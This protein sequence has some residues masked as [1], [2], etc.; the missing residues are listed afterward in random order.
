[1]APANHYRSVAF[2]HV[3]ALA[4]SMPPGHLGELYRGISRRPEPKFR[5]R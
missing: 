1:M 3:H 2:S 5:S 4:K